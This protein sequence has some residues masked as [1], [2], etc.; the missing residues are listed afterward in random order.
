MCVYI[1]GKSE[2]FGWS[3]GYGHMQSKE[4]QL[5]CLNNSRVVSKIINITI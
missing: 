4:G 2:V 1:V 3:I 5:G